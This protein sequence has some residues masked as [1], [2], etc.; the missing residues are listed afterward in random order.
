MA[1]DPVVVILGERS[2]VT[3]DA[4]IAAGVPAISCDLEETEVPGPHL[5]CDWFDALRMRAWQLA[6]S[7]YTCTALSVSGNGTY[8][9][10]KPGHP[11][12]LKAIREAEGLW[13]MM[14]RHAARA[15]F[16]NPRGVLATQSTMG[17]W[18]MSIQ[19]YEFGE[20]ASKTTDYWLWNLPVL[21]KHPDQR[22]P[23]RWVEVRPGRRVERW[24]NQTDSG[25][26]RLTPSETRAMDR[27]R[28]MVREW[29]ELLV[30]PEACHGV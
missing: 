3:R 10:G 14:K 16:E 24:A 18:Q 19:P 17:R 21:E 29:S 1:Y 5:R 20:D 4:F 8:A 11:E 15:A 7:H 27:A 6:I 9:A 13:R 23:G 2:G 22:V 26:N 25:Q 12:R 30:V 28:A